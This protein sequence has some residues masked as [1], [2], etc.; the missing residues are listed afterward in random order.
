[1][2]TSDNEWSFRLIFLFF[3]MR[4]KPNIKDTEENS[5]NLEENQKYKKLI[6]SET[7]N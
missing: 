7:K 4:G 1:M 6:Q 2:S 5:L 3:R